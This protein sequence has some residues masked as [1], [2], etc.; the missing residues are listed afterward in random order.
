[1]FR[2]LTI[3]TLVTAICVSLGLVT[4]AVMAGYQDTPRRQNRRNQ[5]EPQRT[6]SANARKANTGSPITSSKIAQFPLTQAQM[7]I[8]NNVREVVVR[9]D[10]LATFQ[11]LPGIERVM[12][13]QGNRARALKGY[14]LYQLQS[15]KILAAPDNLIASDKPRRPMQ[16]SWLGFF[17]GG[18]MFVLCAC[19]NDWWDQDDC[20][21]KNGT[22]TSPGECVGT[23]DCRNRY[24]LCYDGGGFDEVVI[25]PM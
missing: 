19:Q 4:S 13:F 23:C 5:D 24:F 20:D 7:K 8:K 9:P 18:Y 16:D 15:G 10:K 22:E 25:S 6:G 1:M 12:Q 3:A 17:D 21:L 11:K 14:K 2:K